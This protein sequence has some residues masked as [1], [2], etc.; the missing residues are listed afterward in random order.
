M[1][2]P[3]ITYPCPWSFRIVGTDERGIRERVRTLV[4]DRPHEL[5]PGRPST[6]GKYVAL[7]L[8]LEVKDEADRNAIFAGLKNDP[9][10]QLVL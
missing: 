4:G 2:R 7:H 10:V 9:A 8:D 5:S 1:E 6:K 3:E